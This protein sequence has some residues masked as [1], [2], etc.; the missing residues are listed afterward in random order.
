MAG[1]KFILHLPRKYFLKMGNYSIEW[2]LLLA[3]IVTIKIGGRGDHHLRCSFALHV[4][5]KG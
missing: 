4:D 5:F 2:G 3:G 1:I